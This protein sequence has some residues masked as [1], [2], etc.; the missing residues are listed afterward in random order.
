VGR[1]FR[2][3]R[4]PR[5]VGRSSWLREDAGGPSTPDAELARGGASLVADAVPILKVPETLNWEPRLTF[6]TFAG[7]AIVL[8]Y[9]LV[10]VVPFA[11]LA[12]VGVAGWFGGEPERLPEEGEPARQAGDPEPGVSESDGG[13]WDE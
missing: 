10:L 11:Q 1:C 12:A 7:G 2:E 9:K 4:W 3:N 13:R 5:R 6:P 8:A